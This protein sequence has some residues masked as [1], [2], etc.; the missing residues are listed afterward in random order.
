MAAA[1]LFLRPAPHLPRAGAAAGVSAACLPPAGRPQNFRPI[2]MA[3]K[4][5]LFLAH[6]TGGDRGGLCVNNAELTHELTQSPRTP[7]RTS[8]NE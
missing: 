3:I 7:P 6:N 4:R 1:A 2:S 5:Y 8:S